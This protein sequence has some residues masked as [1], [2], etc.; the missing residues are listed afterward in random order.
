[1]YLSQHIALIE[2][3]TQP[4]Y[5]KP[6]SPSREFSVALV[7]VVHGI[8]FGEG[9]EDCQVSDGEFVPAKVLGPVSLNGLQDTVQVIQTLLQ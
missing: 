5:F 2:R 8:E 7:R 6:I 4:S 1:M 9:G 3:Y